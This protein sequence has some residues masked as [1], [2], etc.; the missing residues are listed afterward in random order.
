[1]QSL[2]LDDGIDHAAKRSIGKRYPFSV[3]ETKLPIE[4]NDLL[5]LRI[6]HRLKIGT[7]PVIFVVDHCLASVPFLF[8]LVLLQA[9]CRRTPL[10]AACNDSL[11]VALP[12]CILLAHRKQVRTIKRHRYVRRRKPTFGGL[13]SG[14]RT[15]FF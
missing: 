13:D 6:A 4:R 10:K 9:M 14:E 11:N 2:V 15:K 7:T 12:S 3:V 8:R 5:G 1:L